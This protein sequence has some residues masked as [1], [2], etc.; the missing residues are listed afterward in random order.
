MALVTRAWFKFRN[1]SPVEIFRNTLLD[2]AS[3]QKPAT[4]MAT[5]GFTGAIHGTGT[6]K[7]TGRIFPKKIEAGSNVMVPFVSSQLERCLPC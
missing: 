6:K 2:G 3:S 5:E 1:W 7:E 4:S